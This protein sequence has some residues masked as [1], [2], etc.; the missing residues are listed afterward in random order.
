MLVQPSRAAR[1]AAFTLIEV[2]TVIAIIG[3]LIGLLLPALGAA[4]RYVRQSA[5]VL[6]VKAI[7]GAVEAYKTKYG[8][9]PP[10]GSNLSVLTRHLRKAFPNIAATEINL[11]TT[12]TFPGTSQQVANFATGAPNGVMDPAEALV[13][14]LG[15]FSDDPVYPISGPGGPI[16]IMD[17]SGN[18]VKSDTAASN[19]ASI[20]YNA[21]RSNWLY[22][23]SKGVLSIDVDNLAPGYTVSSDES[24]LFG[25]AFDVLPTFAVSGTVAPLVYFDSRTYSYST[26]N[27]VYFNA[28]QPTSGA[29]GGVARPYKSTEINTTVNWNVDADAHFRYMNDNSFQL[30]SAGLDEDYGGVPQSGAAPVFYQFPTGD[31]LDITQQTGGSGFSRYTETSG[32]PSSQ[33]DNVANFADGILQNTIP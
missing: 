24:D 33:L 1:R 29:V 26:S 12:D 10:D 23:F 32:V 7:D 31:A 25:G 15:G 2:L 13:F 22:D 14:F 16:F 3:I 4:R 30:I 5:I 27:G 18:Q 6:E 21:D 17:Q 20:Q 11:L 8:D 9:Y 28:Y 19:R